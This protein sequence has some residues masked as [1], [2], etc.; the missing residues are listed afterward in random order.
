[1]KVTDI[2]DFRLI[3]SP[4]CPK[5][6]AEINLAKYGKLERKPACVSLKP[7]TWEQYSS[8]VAMQLVHRVLATYLCHKLGSSRKQEEQPP[9]VTIVQNK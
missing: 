5:I 4:I 3:V 2:N 8:I 6:K 9:H 1:M 7:K